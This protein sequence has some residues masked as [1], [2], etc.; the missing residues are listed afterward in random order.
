MRKFVFP[1]VACLA[2]LV[3]AASVALA[4]AIPPQVTLSTGTNGRVVFPNTGTSINVSFNGTVADCGHANCLGGS[5]VLDLGTSQFSGHYSMWMVGGPIN[6]PAGPPDYNVDMTS[7]PTTIYLDVTLDN[8]LGE[9]KT[10]VILTGLTGGNTNRP[11]FDGT[12]TSTMAS[13]DFTPYYPLITSLGQLDF[14]VRLPV[15]SILKPEPKNHVVKGYLSS[16][17]VVS[18]VPEPGTLAL[19]GTGILGLAGL[20]RRKTS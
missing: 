14:T 1:T 7:N 10:D 17:E 20:L 12:F 3:L 13:G 8:S 9:L 5:A 4:D 16:G 2:L 15:S 6:L 11:S 18:P 19:M